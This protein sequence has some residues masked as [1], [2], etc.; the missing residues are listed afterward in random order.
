MPAPAFV[1]QRRV[2]R[3][4]H[5]GGGPTPSPFAMPLIGSPPPFSRRMSEPAVEAGFMLRCT[6]L[7]REGFLIHCRD[8]ERDAAATFLSDTSTIYRGDIRFDGAQG[9][10]S[11]LVGTPG[12][13]RSRRQTPHRRINGMQQ[14]QY[15]T[16]QIHKH[17]KHLSDSSAWT[18]VQLAKYVL[19]AFHQLSN[20]SQELHSCRGKIQETKRGRTSSCA[21]SEAGPLLFPSWP[22]HC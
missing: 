17:Q 12:P 1:S 6:G 5:H 2:T 9:F 14:Q 8:L 22:P 20:W 18:F 21:K 15:C 13:R 19:G 7:S 10:N 16:E 4:V 3:L 11:C